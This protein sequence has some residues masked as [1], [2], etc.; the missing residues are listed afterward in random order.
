[1]CLSPKLREAVSGAPHA[2]GYVAA[3]IIVCATFVVM[4]LQYDIVDFFYYLN[5]D[6]LLICCDSMFIDIDYGE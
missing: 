2:S 3:R 6:T 1:M 4:L 5:F